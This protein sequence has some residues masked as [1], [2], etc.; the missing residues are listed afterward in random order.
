MLQGLIPTIVNAIAVVIGSTIGMFVKKGLPDRVREILFYGAGL[1]T[2]AIGFSMTLKVNNFLI[3]LTSMVV[4][5]AIGEILNIEGWFKKL[6]DSMQ[7]GD[8]STGFV[9]A[10]LLFLVGPMTIVGSITSGLTGDGSLIYLKSML[11]GIASFILAS[12]YGLG[13]TMAA[14]SVLLV[15]GALVLLSAQFQF[16]TQPMYLN[17]LVAVGGVMVIGIALKILEIKDTRV[18]NFLP[19][20]LIEPLLVW[21]VSLF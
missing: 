7:E 21:V 12:L 20:L 9:T 15:Q 17:D 10:S 11:D 3:V 8:F 4:G 2:L 16:L 19:A 13:V 5:G 1:T 6:G 18:G 14:V